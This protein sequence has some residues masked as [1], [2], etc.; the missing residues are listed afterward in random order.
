MLETEAVTISP[1]A[2]RNGVV[3]AVEV[4]DLRKEFIRRKR[5]GRFRRRNWDAKRCST[6]GR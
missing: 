6:C 2:R 3:T 4:V 5:R 1:D